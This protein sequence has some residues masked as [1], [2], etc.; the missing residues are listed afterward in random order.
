MSSHGFTLLL[1]S[2]MRVWVNSQLVLTKVL[3]L[4]NLGSIVV[5]QE[6]FLNKSRNLRELLSR[7]A[8]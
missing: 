5:V 8:T 3:V 6:I 4:E 2:H 7:P 1:S